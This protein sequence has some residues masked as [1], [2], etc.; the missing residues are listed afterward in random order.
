MWLGGQL[1]VE[2]RLAKPSCAS[3][4]VSGLRSYS[5]GREHA[6]ESRTEGLLLSG[7]AGKAFAV[8]TD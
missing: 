5:L 6:I 4:S 8:N 7:A 1:L 3:A 2:S